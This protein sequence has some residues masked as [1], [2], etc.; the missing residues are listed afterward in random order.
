MM[1]LLL[2]LLL[3]LLI[4]CSQTEGYKVE[5]RIN[6]ES[7][8]IYLRH[9]RNKMFF[10]V[11][12][13]V[14]NNGRF[15]FDGRLNRAD[16]YGLTLD[17]TRMQ[18]WYV[19]LDN[20]SI[21]VEIDVAD[22]RNIVV[23]GSAPQ[24]L[25]EYYQ[26]HRVG[27]DIDSFIQAN[28]LSPVPLYILYRDYPTGLSADE[29]ERSLSFADASMEDL[30]FVKELRETIASKRRV[31]PGNAYLDFLVSDLDGIEVRFSDYLGDYLLL[32]FWASWC[33]PCRR[34]IP[35]LRDVYEN[36]KH[37]GFRV[38]AVSLDFDASS[39][40]NAIESEGLHEWVNVSDLKFWDSRPAQVYGVR[41]IPSNFLIAPDGTIIGQNLKAE[42]LAEE[43][44][45]LVE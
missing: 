44:A 6:A 9:F 42:E 20:G 27:F 25:F 4:S 32:E 8:T 29:L 18:T 19:W 22:T 15:S 30:S 7:G 34:E 24:A 26:Q 40:I 14:I 12:S 23:N 11:D 38:V 41:H 17:T 37:T 3:P 35:R 31:E 21:N 16:L 10:T 36:F 2:I 43:L 13:A 33:G 39:W 28:P 5:G 45:S 1:R